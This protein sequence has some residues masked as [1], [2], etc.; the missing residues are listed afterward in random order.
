M[1]RRPAFT[2]VELLVVIGIIGLLA[3]LLLGP[4]QAA[5]E[6]A[7]R[8][9]CANNLRQL[10][11]AL[12]NYA[13]A[14]GMFP[15]APVSY[16][17]PNLRIGRAYRGSLYSAQTE[18][19]GQLD[20]VALYNAINFAVPTSWL[21]DFEHEGA[22][23]TAAAQVVDV[24]LCPS[25]GS[26]PRAPYGPNNYRANAGICGYCRNG[27]AD[28]AFSY[29]GTPPSSFTDGLAFTVAFSEKLV[30]GVGPGRRY[31]PS[32]DWILARGIE[33]QNPL[34]MSADWWL[35]YCG[36]RSFPADL[37]AVKL[38]AGRTWMLGTTV[39]TE[40]LVS[41][42]PNSPV[43]DCGVTFG[44]GIGVFA[45]RSLHPGGVNA[46]MADGSVRFFTSGIDKKL[47]RA[48]G[49]RAGGETIPDL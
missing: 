28:G 37:P 44:V 45:A 43:P 20:Q 35:S 1:T 39:Y 27:V 36:A 26:A 11:I 33:T 49:T 9:R 46:L 6:A 8:A 5:R 22:N 29:F 3:S 41:A 2:L 48:L 30:G 47:W 13:S 24:F 18:L 19:L 15:P 17:F 42:T 4:V 16:A 21:S 31:M 38:D 14:L 10:G 32:R 7:R 34:S 12:H 23:V 40:F 25:D